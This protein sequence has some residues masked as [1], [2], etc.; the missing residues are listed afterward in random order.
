MSAY[1]GRLCRSVRGVIAVS[2]ADADYMR[3]H[4]R[5]A[6]I[7][8]IPTG[9]DLD[10]FAPPVSSPP[11][12]D[13]VFLGSMDW[14]ANIDGIVWFVRE[15]L[16][17]IRLKKP[18]CSLAIVGRKPDS[19]IQK[20]A[21]DDPRIHVTGTVDDVRP[22]LWGSQVSIVPLRVGGGTR[23]KIFEAQAARIPVVSTAI[24]AEGLVDSKTARSL[25]IADR[26]EVFADR[27]LSLLD[28]PSAR[29]RLSDAAWDFIST[30]FSWESASEAF[31]RGL[32][33]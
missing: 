7:C 4:Y 18:D 29:K 33:F 1:E 14:M 23:L 6:R 12:A 20:L 25:L 3:T 30:R 32:G 16:P 31:E 11:T 9:V 5:V 10:R 19:A 8:S 17:R 22:W 24:G 21:Q 13:L 27:C 2:P 15:I 28:D 26:P